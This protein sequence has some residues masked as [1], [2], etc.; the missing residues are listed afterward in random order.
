M[1][2]IVTAFMFAVIATAALAQQQPP[3]EKI[4][5]RING[6]VLTKAR[7]D[8][9]YANLGVAM[10]AQYEK[11][12]GKAAFLENYIAK[13][14]MVQEALRA[15]F[16]KRPDVQIAV[17]AAREGA[18]FDRYIREVIAKGLVSDAD[19]Q[20]FYDSNRA[21][22]ATPESAHVY[23]IVISWNGSTKMQAMETIQMIQ[24]ALFPQRPSPTNPSEAEKAVFLKR[25][26]DL[27]R[28]YSQDA[29]KESGGDL[30]WVTKG[31]L[32]PKFEDVAFQ[33]KPGVLSG[34]VES[35]FGFHLIYVMDK[36]P[37]GTQ[38]F[39]EV[40]AD[41]R[42]FLIGQKSNEIMQAVQR[43]SNDLR[44]SSDVKIYR[45]NVN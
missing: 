9:L 1:S 43:I 41:V 11:A 42:E 7:F 21:E 38:P 3:K 13:R 16:D 28:Q 35:Q 27:A 15:G 26:S 33:I 17:E 4:V 2:R 40:R 31:M 25:F 6:E 10:R 18:L 22:F 8:A 23:H 39:D 44:Q 5:A 32:D 20:K 24:A 19:V 45:E 37:A 36:R 30:G 14:L 29:S 12:G 34:I